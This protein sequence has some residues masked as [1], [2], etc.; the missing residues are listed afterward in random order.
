MLGNNI[1]CASKLSTNK[2]ININDFQVI[3]KENDTDSKFKNSISSDIVG[4]IINNKNYINNLKKIGKGSYGHIYQLD[5]LDIANSNTYVIKKYFDNQDYLV[6]KI[7]SMILYNINKKF[8]ISLNVIP[9]YWNDEHKV[10]IMEKYKNDLYSLVYASKIIN[11][12][13]FDIFLQVTRSIYNLLNY[14]IYY[15]DLKLSNILYQLEDN[16][17]NC[18]LGDIGSIFFSKNNFYANIFW[19]NELKDKYIQLRKLPDT[20]ICS[21]E[22]KCKQKFY[23]IGYTLIPS[24]LQFELSPSNIFKVIEINESNVI[25]RSCTNKIFHINEIYFNKIEAIF[26]FPH[27]MNPD[28]LIDKIYKL[29]SPTIENILIN[30]IFH[31]LGVFLLELFFRSDFKL[32]HSEIKFNYK[33]SIDEIKKRINNTSRLSDLNKIV[34]SEILFGNNKKHGLINDNYI[35]YH[36]INLEFEELVGKI[37]RLKH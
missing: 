12:D 17:I 10:T 23:V 24:Q 8:C 21:L 20:K 26:T 6:E 35:S 9:S 31:S 33:T 16:K 14:G 1:N 25:L 28:G 37:N 4:L 18:I 5:N 3:S 13:P 29:N 34:F 30:N 22:L 32:R 27:I 15:C 19:S 36:K 11:Y 7:I 2:Y